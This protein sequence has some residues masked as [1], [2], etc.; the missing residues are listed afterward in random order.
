MVEL[1]VI[2][3]LFRNGHQLL[4]IMLNVSMQTTLQL[5]LITPKLIFGDDMED[6]D[7]LFQLWLGQ[8][9]DGWM[10]GVLSFAMEIYSD[11]IL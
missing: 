7:I 2:D 6:D 1:S 9:R 5:S 8:D 11:D 3:V 10:I 4:F